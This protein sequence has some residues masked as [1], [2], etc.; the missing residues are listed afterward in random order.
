MGQNRPEPDRPAQGSRAHHH[1][2]IT[3][4]V[5]DPTAF[6]YPLT[7]RQ[8]NHQSL[9]LH[10]PTPT[11][12]SRPYHS[13]PRLHTRSCLP[14]QI[15]PGKALTT[16]DPRVLPKT[17]NTTRPFTR[18][19]QH[20]AQHE[21]P[22]PK[23]GT[24]PTPPQTAMD[25]PRL[26]T[27]KQ[28]LNGGRLAHTQKLDGTAT[29][30]PKPLPSLAELDYFT[31]NH[32]SRS[33][34]LL[35]L[36]DDSQGKPRGK[37][38]NNTDRLPYSQYSSDD[39][40]SMTD[41]DVDDDFAN[42]IEIHN[43]FGQHE[44]F[45]QEQADSS[46]PADA[47]DHTRAYR[48]VLYETHLNARQEPQQPADAP[49]TEGLPHRL[50]QPLLKRSSKY[51]NLLIDSNFALDQS[52][53]LSIR[54][55]KLLLSP[56]GEKSTPFNKFKRPHQLVSQSPSPSSTS[57]FKAMLAPPLPV[58]GNKM[59]K[60]ANK[61][62]MK[63]P[64]R[65]AQTS[66][67]ATQDFSVR[68]FKSPDVRFPKSSSP[69]TNRIF[70]DFDTDNLDESPLRHPRGSISAQ[71]IYQD[72]T[73]PPQM[74][75][76]SKF[77]VTRRNSYEENKE[78]HLQPPASTKKS[79]KLVKPLQ[80]AFESTGLL[81][82]SS[83][84]KAA[85]KLTPETP[86]KRNP[87]MFMNKDKPPVDAEDSFQHDQ[88]IEVGRN[89]STCYSQAN[90]SKESFFKIGSEAKPVNEFELNLIEPL[91]A[92]FDAIPETPTKLSSR[93]KNLNHALRA[94]QE[95][96][97]RVS[98]K[99]N[100]PCTPILHHIPD[101][102]ISSQITISLSNTNSE[103]AGHDHTI[104]MPSVGHEH[105][106][107]KIDML[108]DPADELLVD[109]FGAKNIKYIGSGQFSI[110][111]ECFFQN[112]KFAI[113]RNRKP[114]SGLHEKNAV[115]R[116]IEALR[117]LTS[118]NEGETEVE[119]GKENLVFFVEAWNANNFYYIMT[120]FCEG[121]TL[122]DF[123]DVHKHYKL[124]EFRVW[125]ILIE[126]VSGLKY[127]HLKNYL[128]LDLKPA[129]IFITFDGSLKIG[130]FGLSTKLPILEKDFDL[131]GDR[132]YIAPELINEKI[133]TP[134]ADIFSVGLIILE[135]ATNIILPGNG[136]P[137]RKLRSGDLSDAGKLS[138]DNISDFLNHR[139]CSSLTSYNLSLNSIS[140][141]PLSAHASS[142]AQGTGGSNPA[143]DPG[144]TTIPIRVSYGSMDA[145]VT[146]KMIDNIQE[147]I[148]EGAP[149][150]L[151]NNTHSLD[152]LVSQMMNPDPFERP[153]ASSILATQ[154]CIEIENR[155]KAGATIFE[156]EFGPNDD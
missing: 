97:L 26:P 144:V 14:N 11:L 77:L 22:A 83:V 106:R 17:S 27:H 37:G 103:N 140:F 74:S 28:A 9:N 5:R 149:R 91:D 16:R 75:R 2:T 116:E 108:K 76:K 137:W 68:K 139:N 148:P 100:E 32:F 8:N 51:F 82:K 92:D 120:E 96:P 109:K 29:P 30:C 124:D 146:T 128:H 31:N 101:S 24:H 90:D 114:I 115:L 141:Q 54:D 47:A 72:G 43:G 52:S 35:I 105:E 110:A 130:D 33:F 154:E 46:N 132:N 85:K 66:P 13:R 56:L 126:I 25:R 49:A 133:Y 131:E 81:K 42:D 18:L 3:H 121:G 55:N 62:R 19:P 151:V 142:A 38:P 107:D 79:Y 102:V 34:N 143:L 7:P 50:R 69:L 80:T 59:F 23:P 152:K 111:F 95:L 39:I 134:F 98:S 36:D 44:P 12:N 122:N 118:I 156:G 1:V 135:I 145:N 113:K 15:S 53:P 73:L 20:P 6:V 117:A 58:D 112:E 40:G 88:S 138:S 94:P 64:L 136:T 4:H 87:L 61:L 155:R 147:L 41:D 127:I 67:A 119:E 123:L 78:N 45:L 104:V 65:F 99:F 84:P 150:F 129:N 71:Q 86:M 93:G 89:A 21:Q 60:A 125:K 70:D 10:V 63:S 57:K 48:G 153:T